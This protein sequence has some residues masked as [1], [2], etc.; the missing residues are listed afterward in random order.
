M[1]RHKGQM[2]RHYKALCS[3]KGDTGNVGL[4]AGLLRKHPQGS[5]LL[6]LSQQHISTFRVLFSTF[7][8]YLVETWLSHQEW[9]WKLTLGLHEI[10]CWNFKST[11]SGL[12]YVNTV[13]Y[14]WTCF[15]KFRLISIVMHLHTK[16]F[17]FKLKIKR[18]VLGLLWSL[19]TLETFQLSSTSHWFIEW[20]KPSGCLAVCLIV[21]S[22]QSNLFI[23][24]HDLSDVLTILI[25]LAEATLINIL[26]LLIP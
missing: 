7:L 25:Y 5:F 6:L 22:T 26:T 16:I 15:Y 20:F 18:V 23:S 9:I 21:Y 1:L 14:L 8:C 12:S 11:W 3:V 19:D 24:S 10:L 4:L 2:S 13:Q 17:A